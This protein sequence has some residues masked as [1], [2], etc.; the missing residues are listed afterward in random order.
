MAKQNAKT[1]KEQPEMA[2]ETTALEA[3]AEARANGHQR[4]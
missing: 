2:E 1:K 4:V 3:T